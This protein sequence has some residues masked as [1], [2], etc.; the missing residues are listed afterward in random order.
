MKTSVTIMGKGTNTACEAGQVMAFTTSKDYG[1]AE[2]QCSQMCTS[3]SGLAYM[4]GVKEGTCADQGFDTMLEKKEVQPPGSPMKTSVTIMTKGG[5]VSQSCHC[6]SYE[7][8]L[9]DAKGDALYEEHIQEITQHCAGVVDGSETIC[10]Y[11]YFQP[12]EVLHL[13]YLQCD[14]RPKH[15]LYQKIHATGKC[16]KA[17][18]PPYGKGSE[19]PVVDPTATGT[20][21]AATEAAPVSAT[22]APGSTS[23]EAE[24]VSA[25]IRRFSVAWAPFSL[26][27][28]FVWH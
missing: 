12:F 11:K 1:A 16:H 4:T 21:S 9:C 28:A 26:L 2:G 25:T 13:N 3:K 6:H 15:E 27:V 14:T 10:P 18:K 8:I 19:C 5:T 24:P 17:A 20:T 22:T 23:Q 7:E